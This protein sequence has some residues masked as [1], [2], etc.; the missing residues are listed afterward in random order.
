ML[1]P[2]AGAVLLLQY[3]KDYLICNLK[4]AKYSFKRRIIMAK[5]QEEIYMVKLSKLIKDE[6]ENLDE[7]GNDRLIENIEGLVQQMLSDG[8]ILVEVEKV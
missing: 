4:N 6:I 8:A 1:K 3:N 2:L 7:L 5:I